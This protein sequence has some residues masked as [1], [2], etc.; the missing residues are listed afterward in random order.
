MSRESGSVAKRSARRKALA[1]NR[2]GRI[3]MRMPVCAV[4][5]SRRRSEV[6]PLTRS[7]PLCRR[8]F[9]ASPVLRS[10]RAR[11]HCSRPASTLTNQFSGAIPFGHPRPYLLL[12]H[13]A[14]QERTNRRR[15]PPPRI[16]RKGIRLVPPFVPFLAHLQT[17][18]CIDRIGYRGAVNCFA[19]SP[20]PPR[21][22]PFHAIILVPIHRD[23]PPCGKKTGGGREGRRHVGR[24][25][26]FGCVNEIGA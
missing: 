22:P 23:P 25:V 2:D 21:P 24:R 8:S 13:A 1:H 20:L 16:G 6:G 14:Q 19:F 4:V 9:S 12:F 10:S 5:Q 11:A 26:H 18:D 3:R 15:P 7:P 17:S